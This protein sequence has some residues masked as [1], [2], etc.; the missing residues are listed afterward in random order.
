MKN[1][2]LIVLCAG[3]A[4]GSELPRFECVDSVTVVDTVIRIRDLGRVSGL[5]EGQASSVGACVI[6]RSAPAGYVRFVNIDDVIKA[7]SVQAGIP[8]TSS[9]A[10]HSRI[11]VRT[12]AQIITV[13]SLLPQVRHYLDQ[14]IQWPRSDWSVDIRNS[15]TVS[16]KCFSNDYAIDISGP[17]TQ[18]P[19]GSIVLT[20]TVNQFG[21]TTSIPV[22]CVIRVVTPVVVSARTIQKGE[23]LTKEN[24]R[25][26]RQDITKFHCLPL[27]DVAQCAGMRAR[28]TISAGKILDSQM[29]NAQPL[30]EKGEMVSIDYATQRIKIS[31]N[32]YARQS[33][34]LGEKILVEN[35]L[36]RNLIKSE[37]V[38]KGRVQVM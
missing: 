5:S 1:L 24:F 9:M 2:I 26:E 27:R 3:I 23:Q 17:K 6:G 35:P 8:V 16:V 11:S 25:I 4:A 7:A 33:G 38:G 10:A 37:I 28:S 15:T 32:G 22:Y 14:N 31:I 34:T 12:K 18:F 19:K 30:V 21:T 29:F 13:Q 20:A 36:T